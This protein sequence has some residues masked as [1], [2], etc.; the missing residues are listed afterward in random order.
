MLDVGAGSFDIQLAST[1][2]V[3]LFKSSN[4]GKAIEEFLKL[5]NAGSDRDTL[6]SLIDQFGP[7]IA[8]D[9]TN[10]LKPLS[11]SVVDTRLTW[12]SPHPDLGG[13]AQLSNSQ[14]IKVIDILEKIEKETSET[15]TISGTLVGISLRNKTFQI[16]TTDEN[17]YERDYFKGTISEEAIETELVRSATLSQTYI[18]EIQGF[19]EIGETKDETNIKFRLL[20]LSQ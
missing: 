8:K 11:E 2:L 13:T 7:K 4:L 12:T 18:A 5:F 14:M 17:Y 9:Y 1:E 19:I 3:G 10:F 15:I 16:E 6:K 20:S